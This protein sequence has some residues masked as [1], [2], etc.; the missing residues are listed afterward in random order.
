M[1]GSAKDSTP[2]IFMTG[3]EGFLARHFERA[4]LN[5]KFTVHRSV[6]SLRERDAFMKELSAHPPHVFLH[7]AG[8]SAPAD[9]E[10]DPWSAFESNWVTT[11]ETYRRLMSTGFRGLFVFMSTAHVYADSAEPL[12][13]ESKVNPQSV[14]A[15]SKWL[16][17]NSLRDLS[18]LFE[19]NGGNTA[20]SVLILRLFNHTHKSQGSQFVLPSVYRTLHEAPAGRVQVPTGNVDLERD[21]SPIQDLCQTM[22]EITRK[23]SKFQGCTVM[24]VCSGQ[25]RTLRPLLLAL[26]QKMGRDVDLVPDATRIRAGEPKRIVGCDKKLRDFLGTPRSQRSD[27]E[28]VSLF[29]EDLGDRL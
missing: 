9:C 5:S 25:A 29:L 2:S 4:F 15:Q 27:E 10:R 13:E 23:R 14:Y 11:V 18:K 19:R 28:F 17:E 24:N 16:A 22:V 21:L 1:I 8:L 3:G 20:P 12:T 26:A 6:T 7:L